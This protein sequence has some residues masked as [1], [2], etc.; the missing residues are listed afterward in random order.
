MT[1]TVSSLKFVTKAAVLMHAKSSNVDQ[2]HDVNPLS[3]QQSAFVQADTQ[4]ILR[5]HA[6]RVSKLFRSECNAF[7]MHVYLYLHS[8]NPQLAFLNHQNLLLDVAA[9]MIAQTTLHAET[10]SVSTLV[11]LTNPAHPVPS[12]RL[13]ITILFARVPMGSLDLPILDALLVSQ[14]CHP[15]PLRKT[16]TC[17]SEVYE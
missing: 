1:V 5:L 14:K 11:L 15:Y 10:G 9:M 16:T 7:I 17:V 8:L 2:M 4:E 6:L 13:S 12:A 3:T